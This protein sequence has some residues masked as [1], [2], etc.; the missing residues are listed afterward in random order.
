MKWYIHPFCIVI[1]VS[2]YGA[3][4]AQTPAPYLVQAQYSN[5]EHRLHPQPDKGPFSVFLFCDDALGSNMGIIL[6]EPGGGP[7]AMELTG[8]SIWD[9]WQTNDRFWQD[10]LW[11]TDVVN[12]L[13]SPSLRYLYVATSGMYGDGGFFKLDLKERA[14][15]RLLPDPSADYH[16]RLEGE[17]FTKIEK[18]DKENG[19]IQVGIYIYEEPGIPVSLENIPLE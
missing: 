6:T 2:L 13:W 4:F 10:K 5:C 12:L 7:G 15:V 18:I 19:F 9:K 16:D 1:L 11:A 14:H 17:Y 3:A 8:D